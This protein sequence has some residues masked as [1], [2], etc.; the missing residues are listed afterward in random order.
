MPI[1]TVNYS[2]HENVLMLTFGTGDILFT[3]AKEDDGAKEDMLFFSQ[4]V[5]KAVGDETDEYKRK[6]SDELPNVK[7][8]MK[9]QNPESV[10]A[11]IHSLVELQKNFF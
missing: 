9:F 1:Q 7:M 10:A 4:D 8:I 5:P 11:V 6:S 2:K 3:K